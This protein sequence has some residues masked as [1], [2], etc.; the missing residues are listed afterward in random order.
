MI[1]MHRALR[2]AALAISI[3]GALSAPVRAQ[4][5]TPPVAD[6][7]TTCPQQSAANQEA[8]DQ[9]LVDRVLAGF[10]QAGFPAIRVYVPRLQEALA[11][12]PACYPQVELRGDHIIVRSDDQDEY[13]PISLVAAAAF[14]QSGNN[15]TVSQA[16]NVYVSISLL[17]GA[18]ANENHDF[19]EAIRWLDR[20]LALQPHNQFLVS[21][22]AAALGQLGRTQEGYDLIKAELDD[23]AAVGL[24]RSRY[25]RLAGETLI[26]LNRLDDA[27]A[28]LNESIRLEPNNPGARNELAYIARVRAGETRERANLVAPNA[29]QPQS[30]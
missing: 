2:P 22:K 4:E 1:K 13:L 9:R 30:Q 6:L 19:E 3:C 27:E 26:D 24:D 15:V 28:A 7:A 25:K 11:H 23:P 8:D 21:E 20:G 10:Q 5:Q 12:A 18:Y 29:P 17:L 14:S 16:P